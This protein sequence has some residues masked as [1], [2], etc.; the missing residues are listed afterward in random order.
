MTSYTSDWFKGDD[1]GI[2]NQWSERFNWLKWLCPSVAAT[3]V[4]W[5]SWEDAN[6]SY[7][8]SSQC[9]KVKYSDCWTLYAKCAKNRRIIKSTM[10]Q[11][12][13]STTVLKESVPVSSISSRSLIVSSSTIEML[14]MYTVYRIYFTS[15][16]IQYIIK[17]IVNQKENLEQLVVNWL[18]SFFEINITTDTLSVHSRGARSVDE[19]KRKKNDHNKDGEKIVDTVTRYTDNDF[20]VSTLLNVYNETFLISAKHLIKCI[21]LFIKSRRKVSHV[22]RR[23]KS[24]YW[25][26]SSINSCI[27]FNVFLTLFF[28]PI[29][30]Q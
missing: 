23:S 4:T 10:M 26:L 15:T 9:V 3:A 27:L 2:V 19:K 8:H 29:E 7:R 22:T 17:I 20:A 28:G 6:A 25:Q 21:K 30:I 18:D 1:H 14:L 11:V 24:R 12:S 16:I 5:T 13:T